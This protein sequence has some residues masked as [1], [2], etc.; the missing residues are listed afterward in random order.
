MQQGIVPPGFLARELCGES[1][2]KCFCGAELDMTT[3]RTPQSGGVSGA[4]ARS[5]DQTRIA[6]PASR[7]T[8]P[9]LPPMPARPRWRMPAA[10]RAQPPDY[11]TLV[12]VRDGLK[13]L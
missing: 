10:R 3:C 11:E 2:K 7:S 9:Q 4:T 13:R 6:S 8:R 5:A 1:D 12:R